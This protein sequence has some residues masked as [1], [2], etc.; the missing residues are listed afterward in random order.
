MILCLKTQ[1][2]FLRY[3]NGPKILNTYSQYIKINIKEQD[4]K[5]N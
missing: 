5:K 3:E 1:E 4:N 2:V